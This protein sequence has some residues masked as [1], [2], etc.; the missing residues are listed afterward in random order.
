M[1]QSDPGFIAY[2]PS[3]VRYD[4]S[5][6]FGARIIYAEISAL[7]NAKGYCWASNKYFAD[8][9]DNSKDTISRWITDLE[10]RGYIKC[11]VSQEEG[12]S[13]KI[14]LV[15]SALDYLSEEMP[16]RQKEGE[17]S[18]K[19]PKGSR[20]KN[21][22]GIGKN[23]EHNSIVNNIVNNINNTVSA[24]AQRRVSSSNLKTSNLKEEPL[25]EKVYQADVLQKSLISGQA[26]AEHM[27]LGNRQDLIKAFDVYLEYRKEMKL[28]KYAT[29]QT[30]A[31]GM[32]LLKECA[33]RSRCTPMEIVDQTRANLWQGMQDLKR[34][35]Q[36]K[37]KTNEWD[38]KRI[39]AYAP[40]HEQPF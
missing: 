18:V 40:D 17:V 26:V 10:K 14:Y 30:A 5:L 11:F 31:A 15:N 3:K 37:P 36:P 34:A 28:K 32:K 6:P 27:R 7:C 4:N 39:P 22:E 16:L 2:L 35:P 12:N 19:M 33:E 21:R 1:K 8:L 24:N 13:R 29:V 23:A 25:K 38:G 20:Q 9:Y